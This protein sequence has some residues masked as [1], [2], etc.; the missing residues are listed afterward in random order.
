MSIVN[1][2]WSFCEF[3][4]FQF[5]YKGSLKLIPFF[6]S[7]KCYFKMSLICM[8]YFVTL[9]I[10]VNLALVVIYNDLLR[11]TFDV[12]LNEGISKLLWNNTGHF[13]THLKLPLYFLVSLLAVFETCKWCTEN[14]L[15]WKNCVQNV[16]LDRLE[17]SK[18]KVTLAHS[19]LNSVNSSCF[20]WAETVFWGSMLSVLYLFNPKFPT[21]FC[22]KL[23]L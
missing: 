19:L 16:S 7:L 17:M 21:L 5:A 18:F 14:E 23:A 6:F 4:F 3:P 9:K 15:S 20:Y 13:L 22:I 12:F 11:C 10:F 1:R 8:A 2:I